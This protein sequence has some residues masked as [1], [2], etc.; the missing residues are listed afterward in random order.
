MT[1]APA[2]T[3]LVNSSDGFEDCW[4][5][6][7]TLYCRYWPQAR[8]P[9]LLNT[10]RK[11]YRHENVA[12]QCTRVQPEGQPRLT[13]SACLLAALDQVQTPLVLYFQEDYFIDCPVQDK[14]VRAAA[15]YMHAHPEVKHIALTDIGSEGPHP[16]HSEPWLQEIRQQARYRMSTQAALWRVDTLKSYLVPQEN[17]WMFEIFGTWRAQRRREIFLRVRN[18]AVDQ[19]PPIHYLHTGIVKGQWLPGMEDVFRRNGIQID[20]A[21]RGWYVHKPAWRRQVETAR[22]LMSDP[23]Y[24]LRQFSAKLMPTWR[25]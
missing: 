22:R 19:Q 8:E 18:R 13:W 14:Q 17:G 15:A 16:D 11:D 7:F 2:F 6:F 5:P 4:A 20:F 21:R 9:V 23:G 12:L 25:P 1:A 24:A 3:V 10:E